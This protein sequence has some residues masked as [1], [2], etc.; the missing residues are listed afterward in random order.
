MK[1]LLKVAI[2]IAVVIAAGVAAVFYF[3][4]GMT[5]TADEFFASV[6]KG[7]YPAAYEL[8]S[9]EF[10]A[11]T[12]EPELRHFLESSALVSATDTSWSSRGISGGRGRLEGSVT[13]GSGG[14]VPVA[15]DFIKEKGNWRIYAI[16][17]PAAGIRSGSSGS[18]PPESEQVFLVRQTMRRFAAAV[19]AKDFKEFHAHVSQVWQDQASADQLAETFRPFVDQDIDLSAINGYPPVFDESPGIDDKG[20]LD[21]QGHY[22]TSPSRVLFDLQYIYEGTG[23]KLFGIQVNVK[24]VE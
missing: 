23:W 2:G 13:T 3:T 20:V 22:Q 9:E 11:A 4:S 16:R 7:D 8:L 15:L 18:V 5:R 10:K 19:K 24:P 17:K 1:T 14:V 21:I 12:P 6:G